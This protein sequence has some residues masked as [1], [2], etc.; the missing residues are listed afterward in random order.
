MRNIAKFPVLPELDY[1]NM[2][3][4]VADSSQY[5]PGLMSKEEG[6]DLYPSRSRGIHS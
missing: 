2:N 1:G 3:T 6:G 5:Y 4:S